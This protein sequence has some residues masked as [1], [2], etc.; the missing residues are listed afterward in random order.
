MEERRAILQDLLDNPFLSAPLSLP[1]SVLLLSSLLLQQY[2][3]EESR[4]RD[5]EKSLLLG[6]LPLARSDGEGKG[7]RNS[8]LTRGRRGGGREGKPQAAPFACMRWGKEE[9]SPST[10]PSSSSSLYRSPHFSFFRGI[11]MTNRRRPRILSAKQESSALS[12]PSNIRI[13]FEQAL[14]TSYSNMKKLFEQRNSRK[15]A[16][17]SKK[18]GRGAERESRFCSRFFRHRDGKCVSP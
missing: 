15:S 11:F 7:E 8:D 14:K 6:R 12:Y 1:L 2:A 9:E 5:R 17:T 4:W 10:Q 16:C 13:I 3:R 18:F